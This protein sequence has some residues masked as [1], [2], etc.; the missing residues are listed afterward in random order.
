MTLFKVQQLVLFGAINATRDIQA[1]EMRRAELESMGWQKSSETVCMVEDCFM[2]LEIWQRRRK[3]KRPEI[4]YL[5]RGTLMTH[6]VSEEGKHVK[7]Q[8][9]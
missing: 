8:P 1:T 3:G 7:G 9:K 5:E 2:P 4:Q 6:E